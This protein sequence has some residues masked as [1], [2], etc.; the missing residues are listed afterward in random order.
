MLDVGKATGCTVGVSVIVGFVGCLVHFFE[1]LEG[2]VGLATGVSVPV[3]GGREG[4]PSTG[5]RDEGMADFGGWDGSNDAGSTLGPAQ[6]A[7]LELGFLPVGDAL[8]ADAMG[9]PVGSSLSV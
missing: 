1:G 4:V 5:S 8:G 2:P 3:D 7:S 6:G 9:R